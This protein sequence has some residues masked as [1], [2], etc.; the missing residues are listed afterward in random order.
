MRD[1][2]PSPIS[3]LIGLRE[4]YFIDSGI[5][6]VSPLAGLT[7][8]S[9]LDLGGSQDISDI[10]PLSKLTNLTELQLSSLGKNDLSDISVIA[11][12][13]RLIV[14]S[15]T[16]NQISDISALAGLTNLTSLD[17]RWNSISDISPL[18]GLTKLKELKLEG[19]PIENASVLCPLTEQ[20][21]DLKMDIEIDCELAVSADTDLIHLPLGAVK[22][23]ALLQNYPNPFNPETWIPYLLADDAFVTL[24]IHDESGRL[25]RF[26]DVGYQRAGVYERRSRA[27]YWDGRNESGEQV[28][29][30]VYFYQLDAGDYSATR[31]MVILK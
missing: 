13:P 22:A 19:N 26:F 12:F 10:S 30:G 16:N 21:P 18:A 8:L 31:K 23:T 17:L 6:D 3:G 25:V 20:N 14:L 11:N 2:N 28:G 7:N 5:S 9:V 24:T 27:V 1:L 4:L 15:L 29:S